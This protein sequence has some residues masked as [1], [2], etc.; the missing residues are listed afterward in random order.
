LVP[1]DPLFLRPGGSLHGAAPY[2]PPLVFDINLV[3]RGRRR[4]AQVSVRFS[5]LP[6]ELW[7]TLSNLEKRQS[8]ITKGAAV[9]ILR[10]NREIDCGWFFMG[11]KRKESY[12][13]WWRCEV[14]FQPELDE[15]FG[16]THTKQGIHPRCELNEILTPQLERIAHTLNSRVRRRFERVRSQATSA[17]KA[18]RRAERRD[19]LLEPP[20]VVKA[21]GARTIRG[22]RY[23]I[24]HEPLRKPDF[25]EQHQRRDILR[26]TLNA[27]HPFHA[28]L[29]GDG[30]GPAAVEVL[31]L[32]LLAAARAERRL[33]SARDRAAIARH[34][35][36]WS[37]ALAAFLT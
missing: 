36:H 20:R 7:H 28:V 22:L 12:D 6:I 13:D 8:G 37:N 32:L 23:E 15:F 9:S 11:E 1:L 18:I 3:G 2:G 16:V 33:T 4:R 29:R 14:S 27:A 30:S 17:S 24:V 21:H 31:E 19:H 26:L 34:R 10:A 35:E 5:E 25:F